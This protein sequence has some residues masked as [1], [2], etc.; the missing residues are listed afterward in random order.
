MLAKLNILGTLKVV[1]KQ[2][3]DRNRCVNNDT[4]KALALYFGNIR[5][6]RLD[7]STV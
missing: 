6:R 7:Q 1:E 4:I 5:R 3:K 2:F